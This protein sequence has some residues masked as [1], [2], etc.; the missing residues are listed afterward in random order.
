[1]N[2][3][4]HEIVYDNNARDTTG[5]LACASYICNWGRA[6]V[7]SSFVCGVEAVQPMS[8]KQ[9]NW[10]IKRWVLMFGG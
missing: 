10:K 3:V 1:M 8:G 6:V 2:M 7:A 4:K 9:Q 5:I